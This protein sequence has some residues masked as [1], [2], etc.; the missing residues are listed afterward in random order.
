[1]Y[2]LYILYILHILHICK[3]IYIYI[4][5]YI[6]RSFRVILFKQFLIKT[7]YMKSKQITSQITIAIKL[8]WV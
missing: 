3:C 2:I 1:M 4:C 8:Q 7:K 6:F 5:L